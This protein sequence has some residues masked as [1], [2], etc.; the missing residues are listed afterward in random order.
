MPTTRSSRG[1]CGED[2]P[3]SG[4]SRARSLC[5][6]RTL[7]DSQEGRCDDPSHM[8]MIKKLKQEI[9]ELKQVLD[10]ER[11]R[12]LES[13]RER[14]E[15]RSTLC[16]MVEDAT[17]NSSSNTTSDSAT[18]AYDCTNRELEMCKRELIATR[19][20]LDEALEEQEALKVELAVARTAD[21]PRQHPRQRVVREEHP[22]LDWVG[23]HYLAVTLPEDHMFKPGQSVTPVGVL[24]KLF[25]M[26][27]G[28][29][30]ATGFSVLLEN[31]NIMLSQTEPEWYSKHF[32]FSCASVRTHGN[33]YKSVNRVDTE[34][35][36]WL[37]FEYGAH[38]PLIEVLAG[39]QNVLNCTGK[40][41][42][43]TAALCTSKTLYSSY[44]T[45]FRETVSKSFERFAGVRDRA[46][47]VHK[48]DGCVYVP[49]N[50][51]LDVG[52]PQT[53]THVIRSRAL[54][55][56]IEGLETPA[57]ARGTSTQSLGGCRQD[58]PFHLEHSLSDF[59][60]RKKVGDQGKE[61]RSSNQDNLT[62][63]TSQNG[64]RLEKRVVFESPWLR[65]V[66]E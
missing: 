39:L 64:E 6:K 28:C 48:E 3:K 24:H 12:R 23:R 8:A 20:A 62:F 30:L 49:L 10:S 18:E 60:N 59:V 15:L 29:K 35:F 22:H 51:G 5:R 66:S 57:P 16:V 13:V 53:D 21:G 40:G 25:E 17:R 32:G 52:E 61:G 43:T 11:E 45:L 41:G 27:V 44:V 34:E 2:E 65:P 54:R 19:E 4:F 50:A 55:S 9:I 36:A 46:Y 7:G 37:L 14:Q 33:S 1:L 31:I 63:K 47:R 26:R 56:V 42:V 38:A 58:D